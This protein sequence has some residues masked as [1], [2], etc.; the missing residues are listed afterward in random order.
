M[1]PILAA[2]LAMVLQGRLYT[3]HHFNSGRV[4]EPGNT[5]VTFG[6]GKL[7]LY[8]ANCPGWLVRGDR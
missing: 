2:S 1:R 4:L 5:A 3:S 6:W 8:E 7:K